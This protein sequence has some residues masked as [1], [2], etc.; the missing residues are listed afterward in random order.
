MS[1]Q[2]DLQVSFIDKL[3]CIYKAMKHQI[4]CIVKYDRA[5]DSFPQNSSCIRGRQAQIYHVEMKSIATERWILTVPEQ[6][7]VSSQDTNTNYDCFN[8]Y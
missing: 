5:L 4:I 3:P 1:L 2:Q 8:I 6:K 7:P